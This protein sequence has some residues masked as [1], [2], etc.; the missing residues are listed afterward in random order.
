VK[1]SVLALSTAS[2]LISVWFSAVAFPSARME[3]ILL[4]VVA[5]YALIYLARL[6]DRRLAIAI[7]FVF[8]LTLSRVRTFIDRAFVIEAITSCLN[9][10]LSKPHDSLF[11]PPLVE[12]E[13]T[14]AMSR[15]V[16]IEIGVAIVFAAAI[17]C[18]RAWMASRSETA[19]ARSCRQKG[20]QF[21]GNEES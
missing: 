20:S 17:P 12:S 10:A 1:Y 18:C 2:V 9:D 14:R 11:P 7:G 8:L 19:S 4:N 21:V 5:L 15:H 3:G 13:L 6:E 16:A